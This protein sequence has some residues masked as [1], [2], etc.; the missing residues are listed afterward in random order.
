[1]PTRQGRQVSPIDSR[2]VPDNADRLAGVRGDT[3][4]PVAWPETSWPTGHESRSRPTFLVNHPRIRGANLASRL[5]AST[6]FQIPAEG[7]WLFAAN[8]MI[9]SFRYPYLQ[10]ASCNL[11]FCCPR[12]CP[13]R[14]SPPAF[15]PARVQPAGR[16]LGHFLSTTPGL[17]DFMRRGG[18]FQWRQWP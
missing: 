16:S 11:I 7:S 17:A 3:S 1:M 9:A 2:V 14:A 13:C 8:G 12:V 4:S 10:V 6:T 15:P 18:G 5:F